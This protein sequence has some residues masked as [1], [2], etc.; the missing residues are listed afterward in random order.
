MKTLKDFKQF[1]LKELQTIKGGD[2]G[3]SSM[4]Q[5]QMNALIGINLQVNLG[6]ASNSNPLAAAAS[7]CGSEVIFNTVDP[8]SGIGA[9]EV[10]YVLQSRPGTNP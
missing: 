6:G 4:L 3:V 5:N 2:N 9:H 10:N 8:T 7:L 1:E